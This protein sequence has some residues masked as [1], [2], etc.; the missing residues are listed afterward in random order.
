MNRQELNPVCDCFILQLNLNE[1]NSNF[2]S[3]LRTV[4]KTIFHAITHQFFRFLKQICGISM[5]LFFQWPCLVKI[6]WFL[7]IITCQQFQHA[8]NISVLIDNLCVPLL[9]MVLYILA[10]D[11]V[12]YMIVKFYL[13][14][15]HRT[16][17]FNL[18]QTNLFDDWAEW[19]LLTESSQWCFPQ[20]RTGKSTKVWL[21]SGIITS[22]SIS[23][24]CRL[25]QMLL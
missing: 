2:P 25:Q 7:H 6:S 18:V 17:Y 9:F 3:S 23:S 12:Y 15:L 10:L 22:S 16:V 1:E 19:L 13:L 14:P 20:S 11:S 5:L 8:F 21:R 24:M 4:W